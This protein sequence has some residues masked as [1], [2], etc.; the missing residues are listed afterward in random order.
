MALS[1]MG[2]RRSLATLLKVNQPE[3]FDCPSCAWPDPD[4]RAA[5]EFCENGAKAV[6]SEATRARVGPEF[7]TRHS[8]AELSEQS[9][10]SLDRA[11]RLTHPMVLERGAGH[12]RPISWSEAF[13]I[14]ADELRNL[15]NPDAATFY[16]SGRT[17][18]EAAFLYQL[19]VRMFG[20]NNLPDCSNMCHESSG[21][22]M[23]RVVGVGKG[24]VRL[25][26]FDLA[27]S[28]WIIGQNPGTN[29]PRMLSTLQAAARRGCRIVSVNPLKEPGLV[30]FRHPQEL[31]GLI[32]SGTP[33]AS[34]FVPV[35]VGGDVAFF[36]GVMKRMMEEDR[37][38]GR[39]R[40]A[41]EFIRLRTEGFEA[42]MADLDRESWD[43]IVDGAGV[44]RAVIDEAA[45]VALESRRMIC[46]WAMG[47]TQHENAVANVQSIVNFLL[48]GGHMGRPGAGAC[49]VRGHSN[50]QGD[51]TMGICERM[52]EGFLTSLG[53]EFGFEPP[54][55]DG[56]DVVD[57]IRAMHDGRVRVFV[58]LG[59]NFLSATPDTEFTADAVRRCRL[60]VQ[61]STKLNRS[62]LITGE[63]GLILPTLGRTERDRQAGG[64]Q[65][66]TVEDSMSHVHASRGVLEPASP[67]LRSEVAIVCGI[68]RAVLG[69]GRIDWEGLCGDY[70]RIREHIS[71]V[72][73][74]F[75]EFNSR[76]AVGFYL[77]NAVR[78][79]RFET[80]TGRAKF[81]VHS[82]PAPR[83]AA[84][85]LLLTTV[86]S[87][88]QF[89]TTVYG[90]DDRYRGVR[91][92]R[93][94]VFMNVA[95]MEERGLRAGDRVDITSHFGSGQR[96]G[97]GF[98]VVEYEI[99][100]GCVAAYFPE[101][102]VLVPV[103]HVSAGSN[104]PASK[105][106]PVTI[107]RSGGRSPAE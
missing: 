55:R 26:D 89:N 28:I 103:E 34:L 95:D 9:D 37:R 51:R 42:L 92:G 49:P 99:P 40:L 48:L 100:R 69:P 8:V 77:S 17:S 52:S 106:V 5:A 23:S 87:H 86:R 84:G 67:E 73:P 85:Q 66:V 98:Q 12:Y 31:A 93:R 76:A 39:T 61:V 45:V 4:D 33:I 14:I 70:G 53:R 56:L 3:G 47:I 96:V 16:T 15:P 25:E 32:G 107:A 41:H 57:S 54:R 80:D 20:T 35:R 6:A 18:N 94:V 21:Y 65:F 11:G 24:T 97:R 102:N 68:A 63:R 36:K 30:R 75:A 10:L 90:L 62:H 81:T 43:R 44:P 78:E 22:A 71:R 83:A 1:Q 58:G 91:G 19:F 50:V 59:G 46:C 72:V 60:T 29:H 27:D 7:F 64:E 101:A 105:S 82:I 38:H 74:G 79:G 2:V 13:A 88:D 104:Q